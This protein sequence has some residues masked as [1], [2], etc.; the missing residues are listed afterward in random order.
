MDSIEKITRR[1]LSV[2]TA[3]GFGCLMLMMTVVVVNIITRPFGH[4]IVGTYEAVQ[5]LIVVMVT[6]A[7]GYAALE[8]SHISVDLL[9]NHLSKS[10]RRIL[11]IITSIITLCIWILISWYSFQFAWEQFL[12]GESTTIAGWPV[13]PFRYIFAI[14]ATI[15]CLVM[16]LQIIKEIKGLAKKC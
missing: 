16:L 3:I 10:T 15:M 9:I 11:S 7:I 14:G 12:M 8:K 5:L 2:L 6:F 4:P 1:L 13:Y